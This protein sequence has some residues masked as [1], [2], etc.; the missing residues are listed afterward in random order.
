M[1]HICYVTDK[2]QLK[3][4]DK[5]TLVCKPDSSSSAMDKVAK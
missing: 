1:G 5:L 4:G 3:D 2:T